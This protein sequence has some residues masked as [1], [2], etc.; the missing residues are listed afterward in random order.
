M[1]TKLSMHSS[2]DIRCASTFT[3]K[4]WKVEKFFT[5]LLMFHHTLLMLS[6]R[7]QMCVSVSFATSVIEL[8]I[9]ISYMELRK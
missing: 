3:L 1:Q 2:A 8:L 7:E 5:G 9:G 4:T 6:D